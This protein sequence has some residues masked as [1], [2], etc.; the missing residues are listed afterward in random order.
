MDNPVDETVAV[1]LRSYTVIAAIALLVG[2][3]AVPYGVALTT[4]D[5]SYV[6][7]VEVDETITDATAQD[8]IDELRSLRANES[9]EAVVL[10]VS[11]PGGSAAASE[12]MYMAVKRLAKEKPVVTSVGQM[13]ASGAYYTIAPSDQIYA[14]P[15]SIVGHVGVIGTAPTDGLTP[16][17]TTGPDKAHRGMTPDQYRAAVESMKRSFVGA[18][19]NERG[20]RLTV[21]RE[22]VAEASAYNGGRAVETG[23]ADAIGGLETAISSAASRGGLSDGNYQ[24]D[25][26]NPG[27]L[28]VLSLLGLSGNGSAP[29]ASGAAA[30]VAPYEYRGTETIHFLMI[31]GVPEG[32]QVVYDGTGPSTEVTA[33]G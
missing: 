4:G 16:S 7:V 10:R 2:A 20:D 32:Q 12:S 26:R 3:A 21:S 17:V 28:Q 9:V 24:V 25:Y 1:A 18:V 27:S 33:D 19:M 31:Y 15:A 23:Y 6:V 29:G 13:A 30:S 8:T 22:T 14:T 5:P 11:S